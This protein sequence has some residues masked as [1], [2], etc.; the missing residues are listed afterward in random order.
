MPAW[1]AFLPC[2]SL[3]PHLTSHPHRLTNPRAPAS[4][5]SQPK[6]PGSI[7]LASE[8]IN[9]SAFSP[10][11]QHRSCSIDIWQGGHRCGSMDMEIWEGHYGENPKRVWILL[12]ALLSLLLVPF[13]YLTIY[14][15]AN[16]PIRTGK[17]VFKLC[18]WPGMWYFEG[19]SKRTIHWTELAAS[20]RMEF[21]LQFH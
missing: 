17:K 19:C 7:C 21:A 14:G 2:P 13:K 12:C 1:K 15:I 18:H 6:I 8:A 4:I 11:P 10:A 20:I 5:G 16:N 3:L 9:P